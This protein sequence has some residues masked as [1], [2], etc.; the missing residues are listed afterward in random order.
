MD[1]TPS[2][3]RT[4]KRY[5]RMSFALGALMGCL[6]VSGVCVVGCA[7][8]K[9]N[10]Y[11]TVGTTVITADTAM[12]AWAVYVAA[13]KATPAKEEQVRAA[14]DRYRASMNAVIDVGKAATTSPDL[15]TFDVVI[16]AASAAQSNLVAIISAFTK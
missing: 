9:S 10:T 14:Y 13:G 2:V 8:W 4:L 7:S 1:I 5:V 11:K 15:A 6:L 16:F 12:K 3:N